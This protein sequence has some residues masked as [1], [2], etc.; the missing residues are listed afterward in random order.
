MLAIE[1]YVM[2]VDVDIGKSVA[3]LRFWITDIEE[4]LAFLA[5]S[6]PKVPRCQ[7][8]SID[9]GSHAM[10]ASVFA[11]TVRLLCR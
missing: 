6:L 4:N 1:G 2:E 10:L 8:L 3:A 11:I 9:R 7:R 5:R